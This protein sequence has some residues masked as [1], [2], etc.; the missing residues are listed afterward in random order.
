MCI[1]GKWKEPR[2]W[3]EPHWK[4]SSTCGKL[5]KVGLVYSPYKISGCHFELLNCFVFISW[6]TGNLGRQFSEF[7]K[8]TKLIITLM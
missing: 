4:E 6:N 8:I 5:R 7:Q 2:T 3:K 1:T